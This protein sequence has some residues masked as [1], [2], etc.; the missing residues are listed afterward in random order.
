[1]RVAAGRFTGLACV[2]E[3]PGGRAAALYRRAPWRLQQGF[4]SSQ[5]I[6]GQHATEGARIFLAQLQLAVA[7]LLAY[8][9]RS[10]VGVGRVSVG[11]EVDLQESASLP[12]G[13]RSGCWWGQVLGPPVPQAV[14]QQD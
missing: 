5:R 12:W 3:Y 13:D 14:S 10:H 4:C 7:R 1:M 8:G 9:C 6:L 2:R 11:S